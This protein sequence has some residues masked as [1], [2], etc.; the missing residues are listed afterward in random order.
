MKGIIQT[1]PIDRSAL[2]KRGNFEI[3]STVTFEGIVRR[4]ESSKEIIHLFYD[5]DQKLAEEELNRILDEAV[6][7]F[8]LIDSI[9]VHRVGM[10][11]PGEISLLVAVSSSHRKE[12]FEGCSY[13]VEAIKQRLPIWKKDHFKDGTESWH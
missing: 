10:V 9:A 4:T 13:I 12:G 5:S 11:K 7:K 3:G 8:G 2:L 6:E 1:D